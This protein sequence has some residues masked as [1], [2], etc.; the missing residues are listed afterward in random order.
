[1]HFENTFKV[2][3]RH[4]VR[5]VVIGGVAVNLHGFA[6]ATGDLDIIISLTDAELENF[7]A[8]VK[9]LGMVPRVPV[10]IEEL[11]NPK[12]R[13]EW[14]HEKN[15]VVFTVYNPKNPMDQIDLMI[16]SVVDFETMF[17]NRV[18]MRERDLEIP[19]ASIDDLITLKQY[20]GRQRDEIDIRALKEIQE[21]T[22][23]K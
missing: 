11:K 21:M 19:V 12:K 4:C 3:N 14:I 20:A 23:E 16:Q 10:E 9:E 13:D 18:I 5:Y 8:A 6:R 2:L 15:M 1:M 22:R 17:K 7:I